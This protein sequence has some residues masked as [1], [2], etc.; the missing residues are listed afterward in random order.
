[1]PKTLDLTGHQFG[2]LTALS[3]T[4][5]PPSI[6]RPRVTWLCRC[7]CGSEKAVIADAL[8]SGLVTSCGCSP[9][10]AEKCSANATKHGHSKNRKPSAT[11]NTWQKMIARCTNPRSD[12]YKWYGGRGVSVDER[13]LDFENFLEDMG[14]RPQGRT[15]DRIDNNGNYTK[16]NCR[17]ATQSEQCQN[18]R[19][20]TG[21]RSTSPS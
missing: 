3:R 2:F 4:D 14:Q 12:Q 21:Q 8:R 6:A 7:V 15:L 9:A 11:Y 17:W 10:R 1:M 13:W 16:P 20:S 18:R 19:S 5:S